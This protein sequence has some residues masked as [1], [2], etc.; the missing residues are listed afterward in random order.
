MVFQR[1]TLESSLIVSS[2]LTVAAKQLWFVARNLTQ[3][4]LGSD[5]PAEEQSASL[6]F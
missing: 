3:C 5:R 1:V 2:F 4:V 6:H